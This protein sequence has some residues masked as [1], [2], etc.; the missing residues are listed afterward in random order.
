[1]VFRFYHGSLFAVFYGRNASR[2]RGRGLDFESFGITVL[3][4]ISAQ[5]IGE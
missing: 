4:M 5:W 1:M 2:L 3:V